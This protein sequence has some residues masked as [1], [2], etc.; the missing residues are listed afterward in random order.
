ML[1]WGFLKAIWIEQVTKV[2]D[3][4]WRVRLS[5]DSDLLPGIVTALPLCP[6]DICVF[7]LRWMFQHVMTTATKLF[8]L[9]CT[10]EGPRV[11]VAAI[12][13]VAFSSCRKHG[14]WL[15]KLTTSNALL[16]DGFCF[17]HFWLEF[18]RCIV[19]PGGLSPEANIFLISLFLE[20]IV[21]LN[22][23]TFTTWDVS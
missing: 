12:C 6:V 15:S 10:V 13:N 23:N 1:I 4:F 9:W 11:H 18:R 3:F 20:L 2:T 8:T 19:G 22:V 16:A 5:M 21:C 14:H 7:T 17:R